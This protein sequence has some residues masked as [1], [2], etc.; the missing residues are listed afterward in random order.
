MKVA[1]RYLKKKKKSSYFVRQLSLV[2][3]KQ[4]ESTKHLPYTSLI[5]HNL[6]L[7]FFVFLTILI[8][9]FIWICLS[10]FSS[11][12]LWKSRALGVKSITKYFGTSKLTRLV[13]S[14]WLPLSGFM[15]EI[16][17]SSS[18]ADALAAMVGAPTKE[19]QICQSAVITNRNTY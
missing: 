17:L 15:E 9:G 4:L 19:K 3:N 6:F 14:S 11:W 13:T 18:W 7:V 10:S 8:V 1:W 2:L 5:I 12:D 16:L